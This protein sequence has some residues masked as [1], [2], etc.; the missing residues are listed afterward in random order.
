MPDSTSCYKAVSLDDTMSIFYVID[1]VKC[2]C[3][4]VAFPVYHKYINIKIILV[5]L[6]NFEVVSKIYQF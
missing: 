5:N 1:A 6:F 4:F 3:R 2:I